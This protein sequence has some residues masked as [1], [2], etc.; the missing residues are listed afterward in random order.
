MRSE[1]PRAGRPLAAGTVVAVMAAMCM[2]A[3]AGQAHAAG[4]TGDAPTVQP[5]PGGALSERLARALAY[6]HGEGLP[7]DPRIAAAIYCEAVAAG[8]AE[9][10]FQ[11]GWMYANG[12]GVGRD[13]GIAA[14][15]FQIAAERGDPYARSMLARIGR[16][17]LLPECL[18]PPKQTVFNNRIVILPVIVSISFPNS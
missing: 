15:L 10:A 18:S 2:P 6:E 1:S 9:A 16:V 7:K 8:S 11:L 5:A 14:A 12:R 13:D 3:F 17:G 4:A